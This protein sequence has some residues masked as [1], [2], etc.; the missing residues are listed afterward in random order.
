MNLALGIDIGG[1]KISYALINQN[2]EIT[3]EIE[4]SPALALGTSEVRVIDMATAY[5]Q[6]LGLDTTGL[7]LA[8][9]VT[10]VVAWPFSILFG[11]FLLFGNF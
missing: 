5:G 7:L 3:T 9:L 6:A 8:L 2:G 4:N 1:T 10:Q 11:R